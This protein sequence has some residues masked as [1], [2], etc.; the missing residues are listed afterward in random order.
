MDLWRRQLPRHANALWNGYLG[1]T[2]DFDGVRFLPLFLSCRAAVRSKTSA[3]AANLQSD[4]QRRSELQGMARDYLALGQELLHP[5]PPCLIAI[6]GFSGSGKSTLAHSLGPLVGAVPGAVVIR[7]DEI[8]KWL[9]GVEPLHRLGSQGYAPEVS[10]RVYTIVT[11]RTQVV[12]RGGHAAIADAVFAHPS[13]REAM[14]QAAAAT[15]VPFVGLW[16]DAPESELIARSERRHLDASDADADVIRNQMAHGTG[17][18]T[19]HRIDAS[20]SPEDVLQHV[21]LVLGGRLEGGTVR[22]ASRAA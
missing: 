6:G 16:L 17:P 21:I 3:T 20:S 2:R 8:R 4:P 11:E 18:I 19:W 14:E 13:D 9:C 10:Q 22:G 12:V 15:G 5:P 7:S 1:E